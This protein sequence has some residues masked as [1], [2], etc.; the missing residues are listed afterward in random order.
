MSGLSCPVVRASSPIVGLNEMHQ[1][2]HAL[3]RLSGAVQAAGL[4][5]EAFDRLANY[6]TL[7]PQERRFLALLEGG[8]EISTVDVR[9]RAGI[10]NVSQAAA[11]LTNK[12]RQS[13]DRRQALCERRPVAD[14]D[15]RT[16]YLGFWFLKDDAPSDSS[17]YAHIRG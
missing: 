12:L 13:G 15:G 2:E 11:D 6:P 4:T 5:A 10:S 9:Q 16:I 8:G 1:R 3:D 14:R 7:S 17:A